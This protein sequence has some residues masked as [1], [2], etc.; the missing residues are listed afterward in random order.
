MYSFGWIALIPLKPVKEKKVVWDVQR[1]RVVCLVSLV[2][3]SGGASAQNRA[4]EWH[5]WVKNCAD[6][7]Q[8]VIAHS[9]AVKVAVQPNFYFSLTFSESHHFSVCWPKNLSVW[10]QV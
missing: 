8:E 6:T 5:P 7:R 10:S 3:V 4:E 1:R 9:D 2:L